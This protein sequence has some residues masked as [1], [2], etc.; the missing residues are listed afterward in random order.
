[1]AQGQHVMYVM[2][3]LCRVGQSKT[4]RYS[5]YLGG[6]GRRYRSEAGGGQGVQGRHKGGMG[7]YR[8]GRGGDRVWGGVNGGGR[9]TQRKCDSGRSNTMCVCASLCL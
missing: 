1:M 8:G 7:G 4:C 2:H 9:G 3:V 6:T 5:A